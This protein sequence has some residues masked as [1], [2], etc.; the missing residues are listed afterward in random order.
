M[1]VVYNLPVQYSPGV[2]NPDF[3]RWIEFVVVQLLP[4]G[5][6]AGFLNNS[7]ESFSIRTGQFPNV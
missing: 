2:E 3:L 7:L 4:L 1:T 5:V 6:V